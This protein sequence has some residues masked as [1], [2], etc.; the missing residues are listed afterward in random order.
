MKEKNK[1]ENIQQRQADMLRHNLLL[2]KKQI[3]ERKKIQEK[4]KCEK[5]ILSDQD[6]K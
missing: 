5:Q 3:E 1:K 2:R 6:G 4:R